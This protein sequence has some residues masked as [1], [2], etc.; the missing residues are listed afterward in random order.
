MTRGKP[1]ATEKHMNEGPRRALNSGRW[2]LG[3]TRTAQWGSPD[4]DEWKGGVGTLIVT[5]LWIR[6]F[7]TLAKRD[8]LH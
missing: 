7:P 5:G 6:L 1:G 4:P 3:T 2:H 8:R